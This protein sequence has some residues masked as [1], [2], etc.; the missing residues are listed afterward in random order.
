[1]QYG[2]TGAIQSRQRHGTAT[3]AAVTR[4]QVLACPL[5]YRVSGVSWHR[6]Q[7]CDLLVLHQATQ[8]GR[9]DAA[10]PVVADVDIA[11]DAS[12][13]LEGK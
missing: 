3:A 4:H 13:R 11:V 1:M 12:H 10:V 6:R 9:Q 7:R 5:L 8:N 2:A